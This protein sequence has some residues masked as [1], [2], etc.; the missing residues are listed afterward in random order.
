[1]SNQSLINID[2]EFELRPPKIQKGEIFRALPFKRSVLG[3]LFMGGFFAAFCAPFFFIGEMMGAGPDGSL[4]ALVTLMF[5]LFWMM[6]WSVAVSL[7]GMLFLGTL[8]GRETIYLSP[9]QL[10]LRRELFGAGFA[11]TFRGDRIS[12]LRREEPDKASPKTWRGP[13]M[14]FE[15]EGETVYFGSNI[16]RRKAELLTEEIDQLVIKQPPAEPGPEPETDTSNLQ[17]IVDEASPIED[18][19][20]TST[21]AIALILANAVPIL[22]VLF[23]GWTVGNV[24]LLYWAESAVIGA[25]NIA[26]MWIIGRWV[27][28]FMGV[29]FIG[30]F[31]GFMVG[32]LLFIYGFFIKGPESGGGI[33]LSEVLGD[34]VFL[35]PALIALFAS[36]GVSFFLN[37]LGRR[38]YVGRRMN[39]QMMEPYRRVFVMH[40]TLIFG[41]FLTMVFSNPL[42]VLVLMIF[43]KVGADLKA[44]MGEHTD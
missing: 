4:F 9:G 27:A 44:H 17:P 25:F 18:I 19:S 7:I 37:F 30:H 33:S 34:F 29:F 22:G 23:L 41:A 10:I 35:L 12:N 24:M 5:S 36:H 28:L 38:E 6:G 3:S 15:N 21:S 43:L 31:G 2:G 39:D 26:K 40:L 16:D 1:M 8:F 14:C 13:H 42:P 20:L 32:H 11:M